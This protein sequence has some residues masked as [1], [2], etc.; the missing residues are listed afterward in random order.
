MGLPSAEAAVAEDAVGEGTGGGDGPANGNTPAGAVTPEGEGSPALP[1]LED[2]VR[3]AGI[4]TD[5][6]GLSFSQHA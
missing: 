3:V 6:V 2:V 1:E 4:A 5:L